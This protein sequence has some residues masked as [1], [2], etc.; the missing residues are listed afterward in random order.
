MI[1]KKGGLVLRIKRVEGNLY[2]F[3]SPVSE[4]AK[5]ATADH[6]FAQGLAAESQ[7]DMDGAVEFYRLAVNYNPSAAGALVN[8]GA[9][10]FKRRNLASAEEC[11]RNAVRVDPNYALARYNLAHLLGDTSRLDEA[12]KHYREAITLDPHYADAHYNIAGVYERRSEYRLAVKHYRLYLQY[13]DNDGLIFQET[14]R[15]EICRL[16][17]KDLTIVPKSAVSVASGEG[18]RLRIVK[19]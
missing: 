3:K 12:I 16:Q 4:V 5:K 19:K 14:A 6:L 8:L 17:A 1:A 10:W 9:I 11:Y 7:G 13:R 15:C 18:S 2:A